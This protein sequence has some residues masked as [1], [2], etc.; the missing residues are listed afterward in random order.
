MI[1]FSNTKMPSLRMHWLTKILKRLHNIGL[2]PVT[3]KYVNN[4]DQLNGKYQPPKTCS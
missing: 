3:N 1:C 2:R 4:N